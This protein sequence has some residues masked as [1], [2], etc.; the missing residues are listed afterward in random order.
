[1]RKSWVRSLCAVALWASGC[2]PDVD[3]NHR[4]LFTNG[5]NTLTFLM[6]DAFTGA[7]ITTAT[8]VMNVG[9]YE[10]KPAK[11]K[12]N[13]Y[14]FSQVPLGTQLVSIHADGYLDFTGQPTADCGGQLSNPASQCFKTYEGVLYPTQ[15]VSQDFAVK[16][17]NSLDGSPVTHGTVVATLTGT[18]SLIPTSFPNPLPGTLT[19]RPTS[20][21]VAIGEGGVATLPKAQLVLGASYS[22][23]VF[24]AQD[25]EG[26]YLV[27]A[28]NQ[29][30]VP[31]QSFSQLTLFV[32]APAQTPVAVTVNNEV[33]GTVTPTLIVSFP[34]PVEL[35]TPPTYWSW[36][37]ST[38]GDGNGDGIKATPAPV[39]P[40]SAV[41]NGGTLTV[42]ANFASAQGG[43]STFQPA[44][45]LQSMSFNGVSVRVVGTNG[46][47]P[48]SSMS[49]RGNA[50]VNS[51]I[52]MAGP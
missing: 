46:C 29:L 10:L 33:L 11:V 27:P 36:F 22:V 23:D 24:G 15:A 8:L 47:T 49:L 21:V 37:L 18:S 2:A 31:G 52:E 12:D 13:A 34:Y 30:I 40:V 43:A 17:F 42:T 1:M 38:G 39:K 6:Y 5:T 7:P 35:C 51:T 3:L 26:R 19:L 25:A 32:G 9:T 45:G 28:Q 44:D 48:V 41:V 20:V 4:P 14:I 50:F 16:T